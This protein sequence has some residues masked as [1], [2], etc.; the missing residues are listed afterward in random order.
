MAQAVP[1]L[2]RPLTA[3]ALKA[4][5]RRGQS[6]R[7]AVGIA[8]EAL[9]VST[10]LIGLA[11]IGDK[12]QLLALLLATRFRRPLPIIAGIL[13]ATL[14]NHALA[15]AL[16]GW[17]TGAVGAQALRWSVGLSFIAMGIWTLFPDRLDA[18]QQR[19]ERLGV[20]AAT[21]VAF[22]VA[23]MGDKTQLATVAMAAHYAT[24]VAVVLGTTL[25]MLLADVPAVLLADRFAD[26]MPLKWV[27]IVA[28]LAFVALG[29]AALLAL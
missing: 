11:E 10:G 1:N 5:E 13:V 20:F 18:V 27:R 16:G 8:V 3:I 26:R 28:A 25:G 21:A 17:V 2:A 22:F 24:P 9:L 29:A 15:G 7:P 6:S 12:T 14:V 19:G 23:E 4:G